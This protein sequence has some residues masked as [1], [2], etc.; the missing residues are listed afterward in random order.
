[1]NTEDFIAELSKQTGLDAT[2][3]A[4]INEIMDGTSLI[5]GAN[6]DKIISLIVEKAG[7]SEEQAEQIYN[8]GIGLLSDS[9]IDKINP[10]KK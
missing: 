8:A 6:K 3:A 10:F 4:S 1:M 5:D 9:V 2:Q 7:V